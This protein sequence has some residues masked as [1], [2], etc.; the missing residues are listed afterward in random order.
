[1][2]K[3]RGKVNEITPAMAKAGGCVLASF[4]DENFASFPALAEKIAAE[5][6]LAMKTVQ[7]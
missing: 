1:M 3:Q 2:R 5:V 6:Y 4:C 7:D